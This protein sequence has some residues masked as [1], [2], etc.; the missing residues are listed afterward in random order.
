M[1]PSEKQIKEAFDRDKDMWFGFHLALLFIYQF[2]LSWTYGFGIYNPV[3]FFIEPEECDPTVMTCVFPELQPN[4]DLFPENYKFVGCCIQED[5]RNFDV[6]EPSLKAVLSTFP[7]INPIT[8]V[9]SNTYQLERK[10]LIYVS[11]GTVFGDND[12]IIEAIISAFKLLESK[13][14]RFELT[15]VFSL[16]DA[17][18]KKLQR[19]I[20]NERLIVPSNYILQS[21]VPQIEILKRASLFI[22]HCGMNSTSETSNHI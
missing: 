11:F 2:I 13:S 6:K 18:H 10:H 14:N 17:L 4:N 21:S 22:T 19:K 5:V 12:F 20:D 1:F 16:G 15:V 9:D 3:K 8:S 7:A